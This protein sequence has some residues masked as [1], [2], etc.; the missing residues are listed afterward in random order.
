MSSLEF[1]EWIEFYKLEP[2]GRDAD[3]QGHAQTVAMIYNRTR[4]KDDKPLKVE[5]FMPREPDPPQTNDQMLQFAHM[6]TIGLGGTIED[7]S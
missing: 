3:F 7:K 6:L 5:D 4:G 2:F 1:S